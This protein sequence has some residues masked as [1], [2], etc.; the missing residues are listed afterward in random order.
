MYF[1]SGIDSKELT[2][3]FYF[4]REVAARFELGQVNIHVDPKNNILKD[5]TN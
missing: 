4:S 3:L 5:V 2:G 1:K